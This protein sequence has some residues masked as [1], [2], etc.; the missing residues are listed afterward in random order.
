MLSS[1]ICI[2]TRFEPVISVGSKQYGLY[3]YMGAVSNSY[4]IW[5]K[6]EMKNI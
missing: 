4:S 6:S 1:N 3:R 5:P 2:I